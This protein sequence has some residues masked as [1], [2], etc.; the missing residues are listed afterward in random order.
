MAELTLRLVVDPATGK[1]DIVVSFTSD[2]DALPMEHE[3]EHRRWVEAVLGA[4]GLGPGELR[5][6][7]VQRERLG[8]GGAAQPVE[9]DAAQPGVQEEGLK[10]RG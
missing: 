2:D 5:R 7:L 6:I 8:S 9:L 3:E 10:E 4:A 1:K